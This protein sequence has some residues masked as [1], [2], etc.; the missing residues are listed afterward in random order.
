L[1]TLILEPALSSASYIIVQVVKADSLVALL[2]PQCA[3]LS[4]G[5]FTRYTMKTSKSAKG[6]TLIELLVVIAII[7]ILAAM[8]LPALARAKLKARDIQ[9]VNNLRQLGLAHSMYLSDFA[10]SFQYTYDENLWM[11]SLLT[12]YSKVSPARIC[13][14]ANNPT[15]R[16]YISPQYLFGAGDQMWQWYPYR[17]NFTGS[18][19]FNGWLYT[20]NY[21]VSGVVSGASEDWKYASEAAIAS[22]SNTPLFADEV[23]VD[24][25]PVETDGPAKDL[26]NGSDNDFMGRFTIAR[27][28]GRS[29]GSAPR[30]IT[31]S[32]GLVGAIQIVFIDGHVVP[33][34]L[35]NLW[36][37][38]WHNN[39]LTPSTIPSPN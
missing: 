35:Q 21:L 8:L 37:V 10:R 28:H 15:T 39:W 11:D 38:Y 6:F 34:K 25:W 7:A 22:T 3:G 16:T 4:A 14:T 29:P 27:H 32:T 36:T 5:E 23:W 31:S 20:G 12:Y 26:Y 9:C 18:Y 2:P 30:N 24:G 1:L 13:P 19:G 17:T 33:V